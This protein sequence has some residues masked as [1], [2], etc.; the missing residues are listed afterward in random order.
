MK[1]IKL[2][3]LTILLLSLC[4]FPFKSTQ[5]QS[6]DQQF[7]QQVYDWFIEDV[8]ANPLNLH[9]TL[10]NPASYGIELT[11]FTLCTDTISYSDLQERLNT[12]HQFADQTL[13]ENNRLT[14]N[15]LTQSYETELAGEPYL[16][17]C[18]P[19]SPTLGIQAQ[20]PILLAEYTFRNESDIHNY[21]RM[22]TSIPSYFEELLDFQ[23]EKS[24]Q[25]TFMSDTS[26]ER[27]LEQ[28]QAFILNPQENYLQS[29]FEIAIQEIPSLSTEKKTAYISLH[30]QLVQTQIIPSYQMLIDQ[31]QQLKG[32]GKNI[33]GLYY[34]ENGTDYYEYLLKSNCGLKESVTQIQERLMQQLE[35]DMQQV[36]KI[37]QNNPNALE[38]FS[39]QTPKDSQSP[40]E[41]LTRLQTELTQ[42]FPS[43]EH[44]D[45]TLKYVHKDLEDYLSPAFY[46]TPPIDLLSPNTI[47]INPKENI[48]GI[49]LFTTLAHEGFP[50]HLY[51]T[52]YFC[53]SNPLPIRHTLNF[54]GYT[55]GW[56]TYVES[57]AYEYYGETSDISTLNQIQ[58]SMNLCILSFLDTKI[59]YEGWTILET[60]DFLNA[61]GISDTSAHQEIFQ[62]II[63]TPS[64]YVKYYV[65]SLKFADLKDFIKT[66][67]GTD[68]SIH[69]FHKKIL[70]IGPCQ[71]SILEEALLQYFKLD[72]SS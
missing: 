49:D 27:I 19:L 41:M 8:S 2:L 57:Y 71:F 30:N 69:E 11:N 67:L 37:L 40:H 5:T 32:T 39:H 21:L 7:E 13:S 47:Y 26:L 28:C 61:F 29:V 45:Y 50:G 35:Q 20:L 66:Q 52:V 24:K 70:E 46:L 54:G 38:E 34:L 65:G 9:Y 1:R 60:A 44:I 53:S 10:A 62:M 56:A 64:N 16:L 4:F 22:L 58:Q 6:S 42:D 3:L 12:L 43:L 23:K 59:H 68:F 25:G 17:L 15:I 14:K 55:E 33:N 31:L 51:Q 18:E 48:N 72:T 63:E 36:K